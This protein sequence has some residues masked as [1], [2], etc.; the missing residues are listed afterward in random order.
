MRQEAPAHAG[1]A[2]RLGKTRLAAE[3]TQRMVRRGKRILFVVP[4]LELIDQTARAFYTE[5]ITD[6]GVISG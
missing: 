6:I 1:G 2:D 5:G 4:A 3:I